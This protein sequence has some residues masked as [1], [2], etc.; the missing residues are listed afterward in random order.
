MYSFQRFKQSSWSL[1]II[2]DNKI[3]FRSKARALKPLIRYLK[4]DYTRFS[5]PVIYDKY[6]G[7]AAALL[8]TFIKPKI[9][10]T[11][12]LSEGGKDTLDRFN[13]PYNADKEVKYLMGIASHD[14]CRWEKMTVG[15]TPQD[16]RDKLKL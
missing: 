5:E 8:F 2:A 7:R 16:F 10:M 14:M 4:S 12:V 9:V 1:V 3:I 6:I 15:L 13:I 11:P